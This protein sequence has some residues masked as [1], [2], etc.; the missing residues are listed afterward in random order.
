MNFINN[1]GVFMDKIKRMKEL[2]SIIN[3]YNYYY[4]V[5]DNPVIADREYDAIYDELVAL[6][7]ETGVVFPDSPTKQ[8]GDMVLEG[9]KKYTHIKK[10]YS[11][12][13]CNSFAELESWV[14]NVTEQYGE[15]VYSLEYKFDGL[16]ISIIYEK[17][18]L[19]TA[20]TRG[21]GYIGEDV[22]Q[23]VLTIKSIPYTIP[24]ITPIVLPRY[25]PIN[26]IKITK[27]LGII[28]A[29]VK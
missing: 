3:K 21:N 23:Q 26:S 25:N 14:N 13:K 20:A 28:P 12:D 1:Y 29:I 7:K 9:F 15:Q 19:V 24:Y 27:I 5:L 11:L 2:I 17:G 8:V 18:Q 16:R 6:E 4:Y 10:L 22:T